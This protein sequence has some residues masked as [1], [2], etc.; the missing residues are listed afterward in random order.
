MKN[1]KRMK[2]RD[3]D[4]RRSSK[5]AFSNPFTQ[6]VSV[7]ACKKTMQAPYFMAFMHLMVNL[8]CRI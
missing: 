8:F 3:A 1:M 6:K 4:S 5:T 2:G 7:N